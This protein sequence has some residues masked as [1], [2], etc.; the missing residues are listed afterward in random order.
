MN[1]EQIAALSLP[2]LV[3]MGKRILEEIELRAMCL[4]EN[5]TEP[6]DLPF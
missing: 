6:E 5:E 4:E 1:D 2:E 3:S